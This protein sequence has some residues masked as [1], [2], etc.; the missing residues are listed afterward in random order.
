M[1]FNTPGK[2]MSFFFKFSFAGK[3]NERNTDQH[4]QNALTWKKQHSDASQKKNIPEAVFENQADLPYDGVVCFHPG[5]RFFF[6]KI[7]SRQSN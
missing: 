5:V 3:V 4:G 6:L 7:V 2:Q 1:V